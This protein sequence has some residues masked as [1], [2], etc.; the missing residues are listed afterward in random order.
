MSRLHRFMTGTAIAGSAVLLFGAGCHAAGARINISKSIPVGLYWTSSAPV[1]KG[2]Y[3]LLC[4]PEN[5]AFADAMQRGYLAA[6][7]CPSGYGY[8]MKRILAA[9]DDTV[10]VAA[11]GV[12]VNEQLLPFSA[13][14]TMDLLGRQLPRY[15]AA[16]IVLGDSQVLLMSDDSD[17]SFDARYFGPV[18]RAQ[19]RTVLIPVFTW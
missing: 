15:R 4:P 8:M 11:D 16:R 9:K 17:T 1:E 5:E 19:I 7:F 18:D 3:V 14:L 12:R 10:S 13:P 6:G 2:A